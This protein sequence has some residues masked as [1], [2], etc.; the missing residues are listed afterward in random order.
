MTTTVTDHLELARQ[1]LARSRQYLSDG[2]L[3]QASEKGWGAAAHLAKAI[4]AA[5]GWQY[6]HHDQFDDIIER[7]CDLYRQPSM[8]GRAQNA[9]HYL[10]RNYYKHPSLLKADRI[11]RRLDDVEAM[12]NI[13]DPFISPKL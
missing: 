10:H 2:D 5:Q 11:H 4:A 8:E 6:E 13:F 3:H 9:A 7:A 12:L 1:F